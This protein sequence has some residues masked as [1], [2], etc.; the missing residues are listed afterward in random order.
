[1]VLVKRTREASRDTNTLPLTPEK[2]LGRI[3]MDRN[4]SLLLMDKWNMKSK[5]LMTRSLESKFN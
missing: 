5:A 3:E 1:M 2:G 4:R